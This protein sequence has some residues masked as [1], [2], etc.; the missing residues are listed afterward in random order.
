M[1]ALPL[2]IDIYG[3]NN[4]ISVLF[5]HAVGIRLRKKMLGL[6]PAAFERALNAGLCV[7]KNLL[8]AGWCWIVLETIVL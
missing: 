2:I 3:K 8:V 1:V 4:P 7:E 5:C 6:V